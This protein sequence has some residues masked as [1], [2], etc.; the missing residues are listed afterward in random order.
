MKRHPNKI[1][2]NEQLTLF[3]HENNDMKEPELNK[4]PTEIF[5]HSFTD[6]SLSAVNDLENQY[7]P[8][9]KR[10]C[11]KPRKSDP[12]TKVGICS[13]GYK[14]EFLNKAIPVII[15]PHRFETQY[16]FDTIKQNYFPNWKN[17]KW[18]SE[19]SI[20]VGGSVDYVAVNYDNNKII[21][22][23]CIEFQAAGTTGT[24]WQA[25]LDFKEHRKF[26]QNSYP[27]GIN[28][29]NEFSKTMMQQVYKK[30]K[31]VEHWKRKIIFV[32]QDVGL[33]YVRNVCN[34]SSL[35]PSNDKD[36]IHFCTFSLQWKD[37]DWDFQIKEKVSTDVEGIN[38]ILGGAL[39]DDYPSIER[40]IENISRKLE[41]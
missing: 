15:C 32:F 7:C 27:F 12:S 38:K 41:I 29:A 34:T 9:L 25:V 35:R 23:Q 22:F 14:G 36:P 33:D 39:S 1:L 37:E 8:Y 21:D 31:I 28:W 17:V 40:F 18:A 26:L 20:G 3:L 10:E 11:K 5:G 24:P 4:F 16:I 2:K 30:G 19:V 6:N 13:V